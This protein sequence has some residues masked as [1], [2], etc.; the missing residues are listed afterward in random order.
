MSGQARLQPFVLSTMEVVHLTLAKHLEH[1]EVINRHLDRH[2]LLA[3]HERQ[4]AVAVHL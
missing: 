3:T 2:G 1:V 4:S